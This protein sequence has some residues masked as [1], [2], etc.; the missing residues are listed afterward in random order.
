MRGVPPL[1][2]RSQQNPPVTMQPTDLRRA[3]RARRRELDAGFRAEA[4][5]R[6][7]SRIASQ[8]AFTSAQ[9]VAV[10]IAFDGELDPAPLVDIARACGKDVLLPVLQGDQAMH[11]GLWPAAAELSSNRFGIPEPHATERFAARDVDLVLTP[12]VGFDA[13]CGRLGM[14]G[15]FYDR[16]FAFLLDDAE[17]RPRLFGLAYDCQRVEQLPRQPWDVPLAAVVT[18]AAVY[19]A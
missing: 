11:F 6:V 8:P 18:E 14:G 17:A 15:G 5:A 12:L 9:R 4:A 19:C 7:A 1:F 16:T 3:L 2:A 10:Y 13:Q